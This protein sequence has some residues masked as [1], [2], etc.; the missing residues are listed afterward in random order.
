M[1]GS[2]DTWCMLVVVLGAWYVGIV[3]G[4]GSDSGDT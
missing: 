4:S 2:G 3:H 1:H